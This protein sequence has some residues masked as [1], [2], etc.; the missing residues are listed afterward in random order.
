M[1]FGGRRGPGHRAY[2]GRMT[3]G[4][5]LERIKQDLL[6][7]SDHAYGRLRARV[8]G[9]GDEEY[10]WEPAEG[11]WSV[12]PVGDGT[13]RSDG[14]DD[15]GEPAPLTTIAWRMCHIIDMLAGPRNAIW[16]SVEP[17]ATLDR[18][19][20]PGTAGEAVEQLETAYALFRT[21]VAA[22]DASGLATAMGGAAGFLAESS[23]ASFILHELDELIHHGAEV[24]VLR[25]LYRAMRP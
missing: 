11:C 18:V 2:S 25:D 21:H 4:G 5:A 3:D 22:A 16:I 10:L 8:D 7:L 15:A 20:E 17:S 19:G 14:A 23:R 24:G 6:D 12:R 9:L 1:P 13:F